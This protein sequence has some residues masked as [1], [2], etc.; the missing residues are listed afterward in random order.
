MGSASVP[1]SR[2][3]CRGVA[4]VLR[5]LQY[6]LRKARQHGYDSRKMRLVS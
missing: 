5:H 3:V 2:H 1:G 6:P 4:W